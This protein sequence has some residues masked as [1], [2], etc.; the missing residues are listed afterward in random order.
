M[1]R[2]LSIC[3]IV[4]NFL[5]AGA[6]CTAPEAPT[7]TDQTV[8]AQTPIQTLT[9]TANAGA[10][11]TIVWYSAST[12]GSVVSSPTLNAV[13]TITYYAGARNTTTLCESITRTAVTLT[14]NA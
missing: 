3:F 12:G 8:C 1:K 11:E 5:Y 2:L 10:G 9:G 7:A 4:L 13:G 6:Q 14:I